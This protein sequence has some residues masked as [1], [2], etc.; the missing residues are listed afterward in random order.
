LWASKRISRCF[1]INF[2]RRDDGDRSVA[3]ALLISL[4]FQTM[5]LDIGFNATPESNPE[6]FRRALAADVAL[7]TPV[8]K[9]LDLRID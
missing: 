2:D 6:D 3:H 4:D 1:P 9:S 8:V 5:L 7:W